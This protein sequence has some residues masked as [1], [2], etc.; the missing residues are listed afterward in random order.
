MAPTSKY[1]KEENVLD[2]LN[3]SDECLMSDSS[4]DD[5]DDCEDDIAAADTAVDGENSEV[6]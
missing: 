5:T 2:I 6:D 1:L 3:E 4:D